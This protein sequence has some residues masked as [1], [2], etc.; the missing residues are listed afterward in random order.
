[1]R[2]FDTNVRLRPMGTQ[3][4]FDAVDRG[5][6]DVHPEVWLP[7]SEELVKKYAVD[8]GTLRLSP[9]GVPAAQNICTTP[10]TVEQTG[11]QSVK[12]LAN[13]DVAQHFDTDGDGRG[14]M[15]IGAFTWSSTPIERVRARSYGYA[16]TMLLLTMEEDIAMASIDAAVATGHPIVFYCYQPH[17]V[18]KLHDIV[19]LDE[20]PHDPDTWKIVRPEDNPA[21]LSVSKAGSAWGPSHF[22]LAYATDLDA[23]HAQIARFLTNVAL[24]TDEAAAMTYAIDV[25]GRSPDEV[26]AAWI[27]DNGARLKDWIQ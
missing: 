27:E 26:A 22:H 25:E 17:H 9:R 14:E 15:W 20:P 13:P 12:D 21:W 4:I 24:T 18:F 2:E 7:N 5:E 3:E 11:I 23:S 10:D 16:D 1:E 8:R 19:V 6:V